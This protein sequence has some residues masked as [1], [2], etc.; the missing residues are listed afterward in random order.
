MA[1]RKTDLNK[2]KGGCDKESWCLGSDNI[3]LHDDK[4]LYK[5]SMKSSNTNK[6]N[7]TTTITT[8]LIDDTNLTTDNNGDG[9]KIDTTVIGTIINTEIPSEGDTIG[10]AY[11]H[12]ELN[13]YLNGKKLDTPILNVKGTVY[14]ALYGNKKIKYT[15]G[16]Q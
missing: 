6:T 7:A 16:H 12:V 8:S 2:L 3:I 13:F 9:N 11:D 14:P 10:V 1:T 4:Q 15:S 5:L